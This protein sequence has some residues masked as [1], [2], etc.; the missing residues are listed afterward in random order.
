M[1]EPMTS[2]HESLNLDRFDATWV[3]L[4]LPFRMPRLSR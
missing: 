1:G 3:R 2:V 4:L